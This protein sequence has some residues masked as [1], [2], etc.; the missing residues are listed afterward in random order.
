MV[1]PVTVENKDELGNKGTLNVLVSAEP[2]TIYPPEEI[3]DTG[4]AYWNSLPEA[5]KTAAIEFYKDKSTE[6]IK[7]TLFN[8][9]RDSAD[10]WTNK[11]QL[12]EISSSDTLAITAAE[13]YG[14][15]IKVFQNSREIA[16]ILPQPGA[17]TNNSGPYFGS[18]TIGNTVT[19]DASVLGKGPTTIQVKS[20][21]NIWHFVPRISQ[22]IPITVK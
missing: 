12:T 10:Y 18:S 19:I 2:P 16:E 15:H 20:Y 21:G 8:Q 7:L 1:F 3:G 22:P 17:A 13:S 9:H 4:T 5:T 14:T 11:P 6:E